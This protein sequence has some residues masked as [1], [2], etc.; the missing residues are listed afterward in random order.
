[1]HNERIN[2]NIDRN[3]IVFSRAFSFSRTYYAIK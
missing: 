3:T 2:I 1:M